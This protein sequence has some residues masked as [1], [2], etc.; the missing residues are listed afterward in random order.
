MTAIL[1]HLLPTTCYVTLSAYFIWQA[2]RHTLGR[3]PAL[4]LPPSLR[5]LLLGGL[6]VHG[7]AIASVLFSDDSMHFGF[8][9]AISLTVW[10]AVCFYWIVSLDVRLAGLQII[11]LP[12]AALLTPAPILFPET[13]LLGNGHSLIFKIHFLV[14]MLAYSLFTLAAIH[15]FVMSI[16]EKHLHHANLHPTLLSFP[17]LLIMEKLLFQLIRIAF[18]LLTLTVISG[19][20]FSEMLFNRPFRLDHKTVF[21]MISWLIFGILLLGRS[22]RGW[23]G[24][25]AIRGTLF[26]FVALLLAYFGSRFVLE[27]I[28]GRT[29]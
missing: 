8:G 18:G 13:H 10:L 16:A 1:L 21:A 14:A 28:L 3:H 7:W 9:I 17:P 25:I 22:L 19:I 12:V 27:I 20:F 26:G 5:M 15:A 2:R 6:F 11:V 4:Q 23:R 29:S 24:R